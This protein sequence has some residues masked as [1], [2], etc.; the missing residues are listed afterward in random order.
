[1]RL[2]AASALSLAVLFGAPALAQSSAVGSWAV[3]TETQQGKREGTMTVTESGGTYAVTYESVAG[4]DGAAPPPS[5]VSDV[6]V[7]GSNVSFKRTVTV[8]GNPIEITYALTVE[9]D[10]L[11]GTATSSFG[12]NAV[13]GTRK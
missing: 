7:D 9:G 4:A 1:M 10:A 11:T 6:A 3:S 2:L 12:E 13:T 8:Q 5:T